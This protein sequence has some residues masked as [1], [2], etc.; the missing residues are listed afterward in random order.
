MHVSQLFRLGVYACNTSRSRTQTEGWTN[1]GKKYYLYGYPYGHR[2]RTYA[3]CIRLLH[4]SIIKTSGIM[5]DKPLRLMHFSRGTEVN[6]QQR[7]TG[8]YHKKIRADSCMQNCYSIFF[9]ASV[10]TTP[11]RA[12]HGQCTADACHHRRANYSSTIVMVLVR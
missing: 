2:E 8:W 9:T 11:Q 4:E 12:S 1:T 5:R 7:W 3:A 6:H 10:T